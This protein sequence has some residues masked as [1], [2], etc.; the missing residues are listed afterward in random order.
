MIENKNTIWG[1]GMLLFAIEFSV[2]ASELD[3][4]KK[5]KEMGREHAKL[6]SEKFDE[7]YKKYPEL[8]RYIRQP[9]KRK[10]LGSAKQSPGPDTIHVLAIRVEFQE[11]TTLLTTGNGLMDIEGN[12]FPYDSLGYL[13][14][15]RDS[16]FDSIS[17]NK[18]YHDLY[19]DPPHTKRYFEHLMEFLQN[20]WWDDTEGNLWVDYRVVPDAESLSYKLPYKMTYYGDPY[21]YVD[22]LLTLFRDAVLACDK[23]PTV[24]F[25][26]YDAI[27]IFHAGSMWQTDYFWD[28]PY[29]IVAAFMTGVDGYFGTP[30]WVDDGTVPIVEGV[31]YPETAFQ[32]GMPGYLQ[33]GLVHEFG[34]QLGFY[35]LYDV[36][37]ETMGCGGWALMG[38]GNWNLN[39]LLPP[40]T[41]AWHTEKLGRDYGWASL[42][43]IELNRDTTDVEIYMKGGNDSSRTKIYKVPINTREHFLIEERFVYASSDTTVYAF[44]LHSDDSLLHLDST[45]IRVW[46]DGVLTWFDDYDWGLPPDSMTGG[47]AIWHIDEDKITRDS[48]MNEI[49]AGSPKGV[50]MEEADGIQ[51]FDTPWWQATDFDAFFYGS[52][53]DVFYRGNSDKFTPS[54][55]PNTNDNEG[56]ISHI[57]IDDISTSDTVMTFSVKFDWR[58]ADFPIECEDFF[59]V[60]S[61]NIVKVSGENK[62]IVGVMDTTGLAWGGTIYCYNSD[63]SLGWRRQVSQSNLFSSVALGDIQGDSLPEIVCGVFYVKDT[64]I[65]SN[66]KTLSGLRDLTLHRTFKGDTVSKIWGEVYAW[67]IDGNFL[68]M[69]ETGGA[70]IGTPLLADVVGDSKK[71][72]IIGSEDMMLHAFSGTGDTLAG[73]PICLNQWI[74]STPVWDS[75]SEII[76]ATSF[77]GRIFAIQ[78]NGDALWTAL[79][80]SLEFTTSSP[81]V[82]DI[83][84]DGRREIILS[85]GDRMVY[86]VSDSGKVIWSRELENYSFYTS[87]ALADLD[88]D[89]LLDVVVADS[90]KI[91][92]FNSNG[93]NLPGFPIDIEVDEWIH[94]SPVIGD[95]NGDGELEIVIGSPAGN[96]LAYNNMGKPLP[97]FPLSC[98]NKVYSTPALTDLDGDNI[99]EIT[100]GCDDGELYAWSIGT[101]GT[102]PWAMFRKGNNNNALYW[103]VPKPREI[104][105]DVFLA[106]DFYIY[107][108]PVYDWGKVRYFS[109]EAEWIKIKIFNVAGEIVKEFSGK[110]GVKNYQDIS[111]PDLVSGLYICRV[112]VKKTDGKPLVRLKKFT[113]VK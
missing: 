48:S 37:G 5:L 71:E 24:A 61:P 67:D 32:D 44:E 112:E 17:G 47:L 7:L 46:K 84:G 91:Y 54:T 42:I 34:H 102:L 28:S 2:Q 51:D 68:F 92:V 105:D 65:T 110:I 87:P 88:N 40:H 22:G 86:C 93:A 95:I 81:V 82:G 16:P 59:D 94:S 60:N 58:Y 29:D 9:S 100:V 103:E 36:S 12:E 90:S 25:K 62:I 11:D 49:N 89:S 4:F 50:D 35:D 43:P 108:N 45:G 79:E 77:D 85:R 99:V 27:I 76:Y 97:G 80:P 63:G 109:G 78:P 96:V 55:S 101:Q 57:S 10:L 19:Y 38:T 70:I 72:I 74:W 15:D 113:V 73:F 26:D 3:Q 39:G 107:P 56:A 53:Y 6:T 31:M 104:P 23:D 52:P 14:G 8:K 106:S 33:G 98:G 69:R 64:V 30:V 111:L 83:N 18:G 20:Y 66:F 1:L 13:N 75:A 41:S 21:Y